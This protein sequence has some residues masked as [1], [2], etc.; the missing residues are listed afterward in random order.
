M[1]MMLGS[2]IMSSR[3]R[4]VFCH[5]NV[6]R[7]DDA[8]RVYSEGQ[9]DSECWARYLEVFDE[10]TVVGRDQLIANN[11]DKVKR[12]NSSD[13]EGVIFHFLP[14]LSGVFRLVSNRK[15][16]KESL[17]K[18]I[19][20]ADAVIIRGSGEISHLGES[21]ARQLKKPVAVEVVGCTWDALW[22]YGGIKAKAFAPINYLRMKRL[23]AR[24]PYAIYVSKGFLQRRYP[25]AGKTAV[26]SNVNVNKPEKSVLVKR[27]SKIARMEDKQVIGLI[28][29]LQHMYKGIHIALRAM[30]EIRKALPNVELKVL[31]N[32]DSSRW[33]QLA[34]DL[35]VSDITTFC[36]T[37]PSGLPVLNWLDSIDIYIQPSFQEG[38]PRAMIEAMSRG[39]PALGSSAGGIPEL[40]DEEF[41][42]RPG[43]SKRLA[44]QVI[45]L[46]TSCRRK[47]EAAK[48]NFE[49][50][51]GYT[52]EILSERRR[53]FWGD[54][55]SFAQREL[56]T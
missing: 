8:G 45:G 19:D 42:H 53:N 26:A 5:D 27:L 39:C 10:I 43:D 47:T 34:S 55:A 56:E 4:A 24:A 32:G 12:L 20:E 44:E 15:C 9:F 49:V 40:L 18:V 51:S 23:V 14:N 38:V 46:A 33:E 35:G 13:R 48:K 31:G 3:M 21:L 50:S 25:C 2:L 1:R 52:S 22:N 29:S 54:F 36:G 37:L 11:D 6:Y 16:A 28:G 17:R 30:V 41:L 7:V